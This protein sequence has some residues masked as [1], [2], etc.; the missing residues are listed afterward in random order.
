MIFRFISKY[1]PSPIFLKPPRVGL[2]FSDQNIKAFY[3]DKFSPHKSLQSAVVSLEKGAIVAGKII[4]R[5]EVVKKLKTLKEN[6]ESPFVFFAIP[7]ELAY[8]FS[9]SVPVSKDGNMAESVA[10][11]MEENVPISAK[12]AIFDFTPT[13][14]SSEPELKA[15]LV[16]SACS[17][18][19]IGKY[20]QAVLESGFEPI[21]CAHES[22]VIARALTTE[23]S[24]AVACIIHARYNRVGIYLTKGNTVHFATLR[25]ITGI[26]YNQQF[27][28]EY[29]KFMDYATKY[30]ISDS[31]PL[32]KVFVCGEFESAKKVTEA[33]ST[34]VSQ[35]KTK[36][37]LANVWT[38]VLK[39]EKETPE[40]SFE[41]SLNLAGPIGAALSNI[42]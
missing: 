8:I 28:D 20:T 4:S 7:D 33:L 42:V 17:R 41:D 35:A 15:N 22:Q 27:L 5:E 12:E 39:I 2:S 25:N 34:A 3:Y 6:F 21:G 23:K 26:D 38:N 13:E 37:K 32:K 16:A 31:Q 19:E 9:V 29:R 36:I 11:V 18:Q 30:G 10:F 1:F 14:I 24:R 40:I